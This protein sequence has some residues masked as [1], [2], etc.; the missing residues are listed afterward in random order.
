MYYLDFHI[1]YIWFSWYSGVV[2]IFTVGYCWIN[3]LY[4]SNIGGKDDEYKDEDSN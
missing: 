3:V 1:D 2:N 4:M